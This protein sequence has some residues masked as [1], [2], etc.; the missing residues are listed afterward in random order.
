MFSDELKNRLKSVHAYAVT[1]F[2]PHNIL[3]LD[4]DGFARN[5]EFMVERGVEVINVGGG[6]GEFN[7][8]SVNELES[9][10]RHAVEIAADKSL[11]VPTLP[12]NLADAVILA[13]KY[14]SLGVPVALAMAPYLRNNIP[15]D[16]SGVVQYY[17]TLGQISGLALLPYNTQGWSADMFARLADVKQIIGV[18]DP[19][20]DDHPLFRAIKTLGDRFVWIGNK[21]HDPGVLHFR[22]QAGIDGFT[23]GFINFAP[24]YELELFGAATERKWDRMIE[25]QAQ[26]APLER[27]RSAYGEGLIKCALDLVG[28]TGGPV[29]P[30]RV[31]LSGDGKAQLVGALDTLGV[32]VK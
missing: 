13:R 11:I 17:Q 24:S 16:L 12:G 10:T 3:E 30:P 9:I 19:C 1:P 15:D 20:F 21:R 5:I 7:A 23:A 28:L 22:F 31:D 26:L 27:L 18:K 2:N 8:L 6:T 32:E 14:E 29:R 4:L 25:I